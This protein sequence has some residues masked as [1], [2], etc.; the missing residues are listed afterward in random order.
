[1]GANAPIPTRA[2][3]G[4]NDI[5]GL[6]S[7]AGT[8]A[9]GDLV[10][11]PNEIS[12]VLTALNEGGIIK[13]QNNPVLITEDNEAASIAVI[14]R[15]PI[16]TTES[17]Q[18]SSGGNPTVTEEVRYKIDEEDSTDPETTREIGTTIFVTP[19]LLPDGTIRLDMRPRAASVTRLV[20]SASTGNSYPEVRE[21][22]LTTIAR[23][24]DG[25]SLIVGG[26]FQ[27]AE[28]QNENKVPLLGD[29]PLVSFFFKSK[30]TSK[31]QSSLLFVVTPSSYSPENHASHHRTH[32]RV[33]GNLQIRDK[34]TTFAD[35]NN[36]DLEK[37]NLRRTWNNIKKESGLPLKQNANSNG[38]NKPYRVRR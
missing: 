22:T 5:L 26:F 12:A 11:A 38:T 21:S 34:E 29:I 30:S 18:N 24:P 16:I 15:I 25:H 19:T 23:I 36:Y 27:E 9:A 31:E 14:D 3:L 13:L 17:T 28:I 20:E 6:P 32:N 37:S 10:F 4:L 33:E 8:L 7:A 1:L 2:V 35:P